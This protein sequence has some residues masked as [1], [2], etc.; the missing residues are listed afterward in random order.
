[1]IT[2]IHMSRAM[3][4][5]EVSNESAASFFARDGYRFSESETGVT[6]D[7]PKMTVTHF[8]PWAVVI[9][10]VREKETSATAVAVKK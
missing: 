1:M 7:H 2:E 4:C 8:V 5:I 6:C 10:I 3:R 9:Y